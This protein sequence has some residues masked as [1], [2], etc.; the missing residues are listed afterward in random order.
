[1]T[2]SRL[3]PGRR[4][5]RLWHFF[6]F[7]LQGQAADHP[8]QL[9]DAILVLAPLSLALEEAC[10]TFEGDVLPAG[11]P[12]PHIGII[13]RTAHATPRPGLETAG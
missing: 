5:A 6:D 8:L 1:M 10:Q 11:D 3:W 9:G 2:T 4:A 12:S 7:E 13:P